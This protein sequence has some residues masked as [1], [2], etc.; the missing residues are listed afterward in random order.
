MNQTRCKRMEILTPLLLVALSA[1]VANATDKYWEPADGLGNWNYGPH[2]NPSGVPLAGDRVFIEAG[3]NDWTLICNY[4]NATN[5]PLEWIQIGNTNPSG[6]AIARLI[7]GQDALHA[8]IEFLGHYGTGEHLQSGGSVT[9]DSTLYVGYNAGSYGYYELSN[10]TLQAEYSYVGAHGEGDFLQTGG[11]HTCGELSIS[12]STF[13]PFG[14]GSYTL[15]NGTLDA[16]G[17][18]GT[19]RNRSLRSFGRRRS[20]WPR[21]RRC[22][23]SVGSSGSRS[24]RTTAGV[25]STAACARIRSS[26]SRSWRRRTPD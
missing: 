24:R 3:G 15:E 20:S 18:H 13:G 17:I 8:E 10:G 6:T 21:A 1:P 4:V 23:R 12:A 26:G 14:Q 25:R 19:R 11:T 5:P 22:P 2:W 16:Q 9:L 7:Q